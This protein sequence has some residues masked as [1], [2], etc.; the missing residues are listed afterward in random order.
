MKKLLL[1]ILFALYFLPSFANHIAGGELFYQYLGQGSTSGSSRYK[2]TMRLFRDCNSTGQVLDAETVTLGIYHTGNGVLNNTLDL[3]RNPII[4]VISLNTAVIPCLV[5]A[6]D[7][8]FQIGLFSE[9][10]ELPNSP[11]GYTL[12]W[13]RCCRSDDISNLSQSTGA[14]ATFVTHI[15]GTSVLPSGHNSSP[16]FLIKD[17]ALV[18]Q[19]KRFILDFGATD[20]DSDSLSYEF[21]EAY[22][23]G[24]STAPKPAPTASLDLNTLPYQSPYSGF[25][26]LG[27]NVSIDP[28]TGKIT[29]TAP[30][31]GR[32]V[33]NVCVTEWR[34]G[35]PINIHSKDFIL[36]VGNC[37]YAASDPLP[38][39]GN[40]FPPQFSYEFISCKSFTVNFINGSNSSTIKNYYWDFG[41]SG[42][43]TDTSTK[44]A[45]TFTYP[46]TGFYTIKLIVSGS[47]SCIDSNT[48]T[49]GI[50]PGFQGDFTVSGSCY[51]IPFLFT[52]NST[53]TYGK[54]DSWNWNF[55][56]LATTTDISSQQNPSYKYPTAGTRNATLYVTSSK[57]CID[58]VVKPV[59]VR[60]IP[61]LNLP[62]HD[63]LICTIDTLPLIAQG[64]GSF[65]WTPLYN[66][67]NPNTPNPLVYP[68]DTTTYVVTL[69]DRGCTTTD[70]IKVNTLD[71]ITVDAGRDTVIC[72]SDIINLHPVSYGLQY[73]WTPASAILGD[74]NI[75]Y[76][77][78]SPAFNDQVRQDTTVTYSITANLGKC[79]AR[80]QVKVK[81]VRYP[82]IDLGPD[83][84]I[85]FNQS[86][87]LNAIIKGSSFTWFPLNT[88]I[89]SNTL[90]PTAA[91]P[92][93]TTYTLTV[94]DTIGCPKPSSEDIVVNV[95]PKV[96][97]FAGNDTNIV[98]NQSLQLNATSNVGINFSWS[99]TTGMS[100]PFIA[101]PV[102]VLGTSVDSIIYTVKASTAEG[103]F[104]T[105]QIKVLVFKTGP[106]IFVPSG[107]TPN[108]DGR[109]DILKPIAV[110]LKSLN[111]FRVFNRWGQLLYTTTSVGEGWDGTVNGKEQATGTFVYMAE[112]TDYLG[113]TIFRKGTVVLI[114]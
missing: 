89:N 95:I 6:P 28:L 19:S 5:N 106:D 71:F 80:G 79:Q 84:S 63:T 42:T 94:T 55:G 60:D 75:K 108:G 68:K 77:Q 40:S 20:A 109:N 50:Y 1:A 82:L 15:P 37:D 66:I 18:C 26:P 4:Q 113:K 64:T 112:A 57:G 72:R 14:G 81:A 11:D 51:K 90:T 3:V 13:V 107:F 76:P 31:A 104:G 85:C 105:D 17:T 49:I 101:N 33:I 56:D 96:T 86:V 67:I 73:Q 23:G 27:L 93:T 99:P 48:V 34:N 91:P 7:V 70:S 61:Y 9:T 43:T 74:P 54:I 78:V 44:K 69:L 46:D 103:C 38:Q 65:S 32:Y 41:V 47:N 39:V 98:A 53:T 12:T 97:A 83:K 36:Q 58:T 87:R 52:D 24:T 62:F 100:D 35:R 92:S 8:C 25:D 30:P 22:G 16:Q 88:L 111:Y 110:G 10:I 59:V 102:V 45:P 21:C 2:I 114:R 29:G